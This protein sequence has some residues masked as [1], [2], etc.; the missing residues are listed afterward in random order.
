MNKKTDYYKQLSGLQNF[1]ALWD[2]FHLM[3]SQYSISS[4]FYGFGVSMHQIEVRGIINS[5]WYKTSHPKK[6][7][8]LFEEGNYIDD[9]LTAIHCLNHETPFI[10]HHEEL[11]ED[12][13]DEQKKAFKESFEY[14]MGI[15]ITVPIRFKNYG[16]GGVGMATSGV[17]E[18]EFDD[19]LKLHQGQIVSLCKEFDQVVRSEHIH[20]IYPIPERPLEALT[21]LS[22][23]LGTG[24]IAKRMNIKSRTARGHIKEAREKLGTKTQAGAVIKA[25]ELGLINP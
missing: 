17:S 5:I 15:G 13:S 8:D 24:E 23:D 14:G 4:I 9:D 2:K 11:W 7:R 21:W 12:A 25:F 19:I 10:W 22:A 20:E 6:Y 1:D 3:L 18:S 16:K